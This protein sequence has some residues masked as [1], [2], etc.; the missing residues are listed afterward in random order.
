MTVASFLTQNLSKIGAHHPDSLFAAKDD[1]GQE[2]LVCV[3]HISREQATEIAHWEVTK[4]HFTSQE[5][6]DRWRAEKS[7]DSHSQ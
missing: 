5:E 2:H 3:A 7:L 1:L 4:E 6:V